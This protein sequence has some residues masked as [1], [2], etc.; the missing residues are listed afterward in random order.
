MIELPNPCMPKTKSKTES[1]KKTKEKSGMM[2]LVEHE[3]SV[4]LKTYI[5]H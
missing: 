2:T 4:I 5:K 3:S 1:S